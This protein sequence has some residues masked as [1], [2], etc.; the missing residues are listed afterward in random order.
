[1]FVGIIGDECDVDVDCSAAV[2]S[3]NCTNAECFCDSGYLANV[4]GTTCTKRTYT[5]VVI[6]K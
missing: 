6:R 1:M 2:G 3:S 4:D 5:N